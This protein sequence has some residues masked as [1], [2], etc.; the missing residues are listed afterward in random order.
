MV[1]RGVDGLLVRHGLSSKSVKALATIDR[2]SDEPAFLSLAERRGWP[3]RAFTAEEL[4]AAPGI[5]SPS[6]TVKRFVGTRGVAEPAALLAARAEKLL[7][8]KQTY[9]ET[10]A[11]RSM[12]FAV[13]R[14]PFPKRDLEAHHG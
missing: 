8:A 1:E 4:D 11:S 2:K 10:G 3:L 12:T 7:V 9:T 14:I 6:E 5:E 13:A